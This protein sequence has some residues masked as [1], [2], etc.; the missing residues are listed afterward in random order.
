MGT[1]IF[2]VS[3]LIL[4]LLQQFPG[5][6]K[7]FSVERYREAQVSGDFDP[8]AN[9]QTLQVFLE[10]ILEAVD[11]PLFFVIDG[12]DE[13]ERLSRNQLLKLL[14][15]LSHRSQN[16]KVILPSRPEGEILQR[17]RESPKIEMGSN[18]ERDA[19]I[20][21][22]RVEDSLDYLAENVQA[23]IISRAADLAELVDH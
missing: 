23:L 7:V 2:I 8:A 18:A 13:C 17:L 15:N 9:I 20:V 4:Q 19:V 12:L 21:R 10:E 6:K 14:T 5:L 3:T 16:L 1:A 11:R 22:K